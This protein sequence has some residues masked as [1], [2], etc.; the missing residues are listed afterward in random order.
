MKQRL[1]TP[2]PLTTDPRVRDAMLRDWGSRDRDFIA[3]TAELRERLLA[4]AAGEASHVAVPLQGSG[5][6]I[7][8]A[9]VAT[10][11]GGAHKLLVLVNGAYGRRMVTIAQ[12]LGRS[13]EAIDWP[14]NHPV[15]PD[16]VGARLAAD[17]AISHVAFV[18]CET[19]TGILNPLESVAEVVA[20]AGRHLLVDAMASFG[21]LPIDLAATPITAVLASSNKCIEG[22][23]GIA[24]A[25]VA[26]PLLQE[27]AGR[28]PS[29]SL[30]L[31]AQWRGFEK[32]GQWRF[33]PPVQVVA[34]TVEA[35]RLLEYEGGPPVREARYRGNLTILRSGLE[36]LGHRLY[37]DPAVQ[38][39]TIAT[40]A[41]AADRPFDF[42][43]LYE[44]LADRGLVIYPGK[45]TQA[46]TFRIGCIGALS[47][48]DFREL[49]A[50]FAE[51]AAAPT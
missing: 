45:L 17:P 32:D 26:R 7:L 50:A 23:P 19:T 15:D 35:L 28:S 14:E 47:E 30:D 24:F 40:F 4:V 20:R 42:A 3:L 11:I 38:G 29:L 39:P 22:P 31:H 2:G 5:T 10:L 37:L 13:V 21:A 16:A 1:F 12:R 34:G 48:A 41:P 27:A 6:Y 49:V 43:G 51:D 25:L 44:R 46:E 33:T 18:H 36:P 8:E 9:A